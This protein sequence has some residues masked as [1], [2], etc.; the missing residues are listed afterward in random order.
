[1]REEVKWTSQW[2]FVPDVSWLSS[3]HVTL[4]IL[5]T[6]APKFSTNEVRNRNINRTNR[7]SP[8]HCETSRT[9]VTYAPETL[10]HPCE[11]VKR[12]G[13]VRWQ[14]ET[15][16]EIR[17]GTCWTGSGV[18]CQVTLRAR[19]AQPEAPSLPASLSSRG[20]SDVCLFWHDSHKSRA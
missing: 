19:T 13:S 18:N 2:D 8:L 3:N 12:G 11:S 7:R 4:S 16:W 17:A 14:W 20:L 9:V 1:M 6:F 10:R 5:H 15:R